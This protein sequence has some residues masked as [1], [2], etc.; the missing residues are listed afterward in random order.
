M[1]VYVYS[2]VKFIFL[3]IY[4]RKKKFKEKSWKKIFLGYDDISPG[5]IILD[6][7]ILKIGSKRVFGFLKY[8]SESF[9]YNYNSIKKRR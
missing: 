3:A 5:Y 6:F 1:V 8:Q 2:I 7:E 9:N 4:K